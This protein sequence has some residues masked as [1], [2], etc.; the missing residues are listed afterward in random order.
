MKK[1]ES[2]PKGRG[3]TVVMAIM[4]C[5][6]IFLAGMLFSINKKLTHVQATMERRISE[7]EERQN[8]VEK[9]LGILKNIGPEIETVHKHWETVRKKMAAFEG[10][11]EKFVDELTESFSKEQKEK[12]RKALDKLFRLWE[13]FGEF[14]EELEAE[15]RE[16]REG[17]QGEGSKD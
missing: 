1:G 16:M 6:L 15:D 5:I 4:C 2:P 13:A 9:S 10:A 14:L 17:R 12:M 3:I 8:S 11:L 7:L